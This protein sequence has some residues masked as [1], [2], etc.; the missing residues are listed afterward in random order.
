MASRQSA[1]K[2]CEAIWKRAHPTLPGARR[3]TH[4]GPPRPHLCAP[5]PPQVRHPFAQWDFH[6]LSAACDSTFLLLAHAEGTPEL[7][8]KG[9][10]VQA[11]MGGS[12]VLLFLGSPRISSLDEL[13]VCGGAVA[14]GGG[15]SMAFH[16]WTGWATGCGVGRKRSQLPHTQFLALKGSAFY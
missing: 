3:P 6:D 11:E 7:Q 13:R 15:A 4:V 1:L 12:E 10:F 8:L 16:C 2:G 9:Q 5:P 14:G